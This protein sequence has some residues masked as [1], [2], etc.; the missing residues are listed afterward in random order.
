MTVG[1]VE[2][3]N[4]FAY[5]PFL[6]EE[7]IWLLSDYCFSLSIYDNGFNFRVAIQLQTLKPI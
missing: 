5:E 1:E 2:F 4:Q 3:Y 6:L 7:I